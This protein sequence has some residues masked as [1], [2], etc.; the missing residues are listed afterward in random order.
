M[1]YTYP[2]IFYPWSEGTGYTA[3]VPDLSGCISEGDDLD[4]AI[5]MIRDAASGWILDELRD[6]KELPSPRKIADI[7]LS[8]DGFITLIEFEVNV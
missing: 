2:V 7:K 5:F 6:G 4:E 3:E 8:E 1:K